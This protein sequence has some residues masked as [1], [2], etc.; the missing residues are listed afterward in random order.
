QACEEGPEFPPYLLNFLPNTPDA[1]A[2]IKRILDEEQNADVGALDSSQQEFRRYLREWLMCKSEYMRDE[3]ISGASSVSDESLVIGREGKG[4][5]QLQQLTALA[6][7][8]WKTAEPL[9]KSYAE[10]AAPF[11]AAVALSLLY[12]HAAQNN[13][14]AEADSYRNRLK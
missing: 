9:L 4:P 3:L 1:H 6:R 14:S 5:Q 10:G 13:Q 12:E 11:T 2:R 7:L 8:D